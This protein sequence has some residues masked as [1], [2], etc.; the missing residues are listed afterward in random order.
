MTQC[1]RR[2]TQVLLVSLLL[3]VLGS[4]A[5][6]TDGPYVL[7]TSEGQWSA[8]W[9]EGD[10]SAPKISE[11]TVR[12]G[13][14]IT[15]PA[16]G[17]RSAFEVR[18]RGDPAITPSEVSLSS[19]TSLFVI[20]DT[21]GEF[22]I[23]TELF[24]KHRIIDSK[25]NWSFG[26]GHLVILGDVFD[27]GPN[28]TELLWLFYKLEGEARAA[29]GGVHLVLGN[30]ETL[31]LL[32]SRQDLNAKYA[33]VAKALA[34]PTYASLWDTRSLLG[35]WLR[36]KPAVQKIGNFLC[37]HGGISAELVN[38]KMALDEINETVRDVLGYTEP[39]AGPKPRY[40]L[41]DLALL[42][43][44]PAATDADRERAGFITFGKLGPLWYRGY[45]PEVARQGGFPIA[46]D[47]DVEAAL[48]FFGVTKILVGHTIVPTVTSLYG[49][50]VVAVQVYPH[51]DEQT[52]ASVAEGLRIENGRVLRAR[53]DGTTEP[54]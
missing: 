2:R 53:I 48:R 54:L 39:Y 12:A 52:G 23:A 21:H 36:T 15:V 8:R 45:F 1:F 46:S 19:G 18:L 13:D 32:G 50:K 5:S 3:P 27:R 34:V 6:I 43:G 41:A 31:V 38:R 30:H 51:R 20:A 42:G 40:A 25:L 7:Q 33:E 49:G 44:A 9:I 4:A 14:V 16:V 26:K 35:R 17:P 22:E 24:Q 47:T 28:Q 37:L 29:G 10:D 11:R